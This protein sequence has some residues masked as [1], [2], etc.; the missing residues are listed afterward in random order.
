M[1]SVLYRVNKVFRETLGITDLVVTPATTPGDVREW[2]SVAHV[3]L[4]LA[5]ES[6]FDT[7]LTAEELGSITKVGDILE[8]LR[9]RGIAD[10]SDSP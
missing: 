3:Q 9:K 10:A 1:P 7:M 4:F 8:L 5:L 6:E 2:D